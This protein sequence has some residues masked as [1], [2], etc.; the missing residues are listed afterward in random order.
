MKKISALIKMSNKSIFENFALFFT[1]VLIVLIVMAVGI[2]VCAKALFEPMAANPAVTG[3]EIG[4]A[5]QAVLLSLMLVSIGI[6]YTVM[7]AVPTTKEK[8][9]GN[10]ESMLAASAGIGDI[11][12][13]KAISLFL[14]SLLTSLVLVIPGC[15]ILKWVSIPSAPGMVLNGWFLVTIFVGVPILYLSECLLITL[16][17]LCF[18]SE[19]GNVI[20]SIF[21]IG[22][23][24]LVINLVARGALNPT[25]PVLLIIFL[26]LAAAM[27]VL[28]MVLF[29][30]VD[31]EKVVLSC[32]AEASTTGRRR[33]KRPAKA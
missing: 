11:W 16:I 9:N 26:A 27:F 19:G 2:V 29:R 3:E 14:V 22:I 20:G 5:F 31:K 18:S 30:K 24:V 21:C 4:F 7:L 8:A 15:L 25:G 32:K 12:V 6:C 33:V 23:T 17:A 10:V 13:A 1:Y 28:S